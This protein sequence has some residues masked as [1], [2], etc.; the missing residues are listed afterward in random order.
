MGTER[1][2]GCFCWGASLFICETSHHNSTIS[3]VVTK[4]WS[5]VSLHSSLPQN[6]EP[7]FTSL[8]NDKKK[9]VTTARTLEA[10]TSHFLRGDCPLM[11]RLVTF[12][13]SKHCNTSCFHENDESSNHKPVKPSIRNTYTCVAALHFSTQSSVRDLSLSTQNTKSSNLIFP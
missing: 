3:Y 2:W 13:S 1:L 7:V 11:R 9:T 6:T 12:P 4:L 8:N 10:I 5:G